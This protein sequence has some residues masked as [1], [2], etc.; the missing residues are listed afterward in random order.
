MLCTFLSFMLFSA[1]ECTNVLLLLRLIAL[2][3]CISCNKI[4]PSALISDQCK[5][6]GETNETFNKLLI[7]W[8]V[9]STIQKIVR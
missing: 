6:I 4:A 2:M 9:F 8:L 7:C 1:N 5:Q 3:F